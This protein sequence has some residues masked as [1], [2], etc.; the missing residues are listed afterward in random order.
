MQT[1]RYKAL[2]K[3]GAK[4]NG[5][6][7]AQNEYEAVVQ[8]KEHC[9][10]VTDI[11]KVKEKNS[12]LTKE[13]GSKKPSPKILS[14]MC[15][16]FSVLLQSG[17]NIRRVVETVSAQTSDKRLRK[18]LADVAEDVGGGYSLAG[19]FENQGNYFPIALIETVRAGEES[20]ALEHSFE[21]LTSY[22][23][24]SYKTKAKVKSA[25]TYPIFVLIIAVVVV[26][27]M[28]AKVIPTFL[29]I[30]DEL[31]AEL[32]LCTISLIKMT[33]FFQRAWFL[34]LILI[35]GGILFWR[36]YRKTEKG[37]LRC[38]V[39][40]MKIPVLGKIN[41]M[42]GASQFANTMATLLSAGLGVGRALMITA[43]VLDNRYLSKAADRC[44]MGVEAGRRLGECLTE[45]N[46]LPNLLAEMTAVGEET[47]TLEE[48]L[49]KVGSYFDNEVETSTQRAIS[50]L[51]PT[52]LV[53]AAII[54]GYIVFSL[55]LPM[56]SMY[57]AM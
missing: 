54:A 19:A 43:R 12:I 35:F 36:F 13:I 20:G 3:Q 41:R 47:G 30:F 37:A 31:D 4:V 49:T 10:V 56:F 9:S 40:A 14:M 22:Y 5:V 34:L 23:E 1:Y 6:V 55:Y 15:S 24:S 7:E 42:N 51:E 46:Y 52:L 25:L 45:V 32:P 57:G 26:I 44:I 28:M 16:Q 18:I 33:E 48:T 17:L 2:S 8:I 38:S 27:V 53:V 29:G 21:R 39:L 50:L 11:W